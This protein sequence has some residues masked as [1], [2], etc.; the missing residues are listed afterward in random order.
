MA[1]GSSRP[2]SPHLSVYRKLDTMVMSG[3]HRITGFC[4]AI[5]TLHLTCWF[6]SAAAGPEAFN[7][8]QAFS[9][10]WFGMLMLFGWTFCLF[11]HLAN[12][13][14]HLIWDV[15]MSFEIKNIVSGGWF[16]TAIAVGLTVVTWIAGLAS[17]GLK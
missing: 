3:F 17:L 14:R 11:Y 13:V 10:S 7:A 6:L 8:I 4:L 16:A 9:R 5:G 2:L 1:Q 15:G 12:G